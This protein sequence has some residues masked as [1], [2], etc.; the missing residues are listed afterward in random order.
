M[1]A[2]QTNKNKNY[3]ETCK[4]IDPLNVY[5]GRD[6][7]LLKLLSK[8]MNFDYVYVDP[9]E[10]TQGSLINGDENNL[11]YSGGLGM[12]QRSE[13]DMLFGDIAIN[14]ERRKIVEFSFFTLAD[15]GAFVTHSPR[16][17]NEALAL[18]R[19]FRLEIWPPLILTIIISG[20]V[21]Y[22]IILAPLWFDKSTKSYNTFRRENYRHLLLTCIWFIIS[23]F[24]RQGKCLF[25]QLY[26]RNKKNINKTNESHCATL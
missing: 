25:Y 3:S 2:N 18:I 5:G 21:F 17:L 20:P 23:I 13:A 1:Y 19:P 9:P 8:K 24:L 6:D 15:S 16:P 10:R 4:L 14:L 12:L 22:F 7:S 11:T 26:K